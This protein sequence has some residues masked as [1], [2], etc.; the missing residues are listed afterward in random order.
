MS[1]GE[2]LVAI[3]LGSNSFH[4]IIAR[5]LSGSIQ[6]VLTQKQSVRLASGLDEHKNL[7]EDAIQRGLDCLSEFQQQLQGL[8]N[9]RVKIVAT[10]TL[11]VAKNS[12]EFLK[13]AKAIL[14]YDINIISGEQ[15]AKLIYQGVAHNY[16]LKG[17][18]MVMDIGGGSTE[19]IIGKQFKT[20]F[21]QSMEMGSRSFAIAYFSD[22][23]VTCAGMRAAQTQARHIL[24]P[25][26]EPCI[27]AGWKSVIGT[28][29]SF[30]AIRNIMLELYADSHITEKRLRRVINLF[31]EA[32][33]YD[34]LP[35]NCIEE[36]RFVLTASALAII[37]SFMDLFA[38]KKID[39]SSAALREG[40]LNQLNRTEQDISPRE[41]TIRNLLDLHNIA[42]VFSERVLLQLQLFKEQLAEQD[43]KLPSTQTMLLK[44]AAL[45][46][47]IGLNINSKKRQQHGAYIL[48][49]S[50]LPGF[51]EQEQ[52]VIASMV[53]HHRGKIKEIQDF[54]L[55]SK[56]EYLKLVQLLRVAIILTQ[57]RG[58]FPP[59]EAKIHYEGDMLE[60]TLPAVLL[61]NSEILALLEKEVLQQ[62]K[63]GLKLKIIAETIIF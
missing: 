41:R 37:S 20:K 29:G 38:V 52:L 42:Q 59:Q 55:L 50:N 30:K 6:T 17:S 47:E 28:S 1:D 40:V 46:H 26:L 3:D 53:G 23:Q 11:R 56:A 51:S 9:P 31:I 2:H 18:T 44:Y 54:D 22:E 43:L 45:V 15:E 35:L 13:R 36:S 4:L 8:N 5:E 39:V 57:G 16:P 32:K 19:F 49:H 10:Y 61:K 24:F 14:P 58:D 63:V 25:I 34:K 60:M 33:T 62:S 21:A 7:S 12:D 48:E 27:R